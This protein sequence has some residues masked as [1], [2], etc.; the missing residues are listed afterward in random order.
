MKSIFVAIAFISASIALPIEAA[1]PPFDPPC[2]AAAAEAVF[3]SDDGQRQVMRAS[4]GLVVE[5]LTGQRA[6]DHF[7]RLRAERPERFARAGQALARR[8][9][10]PTRDVI[11]YRTLSLAGAYAP[12]D[13]PEGFRPQPGL[14]L[15]ADSFS[16]SEGEIIFW[17]WDDGNDATWEGMAYVERYSDGAYVNYDAQADISTDDSWH[18]VWSEE[19]SSGGG[20]WDGGDDCRECI[21]PTSN[22]TGGTIVPAVTGNPSAALGHGMLDL[23]LAQA[24]SRWDGYLGCALSRCVG[25]GVACKWTGVAWGKC[26][27]GC[28]AGM[29]FVACAVERLLPF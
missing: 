13:L 2:S 29:G 22:S 19:T 3:V 6:V 15:A 10:Q 20:G 27:G 4:N 12:S 18:S 1:T 23:R 11:A 7:R 9:Y 17:S 8:G 5:K 24:S 14:R 21:Y 26:T 25:C 16:E 28:C